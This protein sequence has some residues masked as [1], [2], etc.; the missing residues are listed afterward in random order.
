MKKLILFFLLIDSFVFGQ[1]N[2]YSIAVY[3]DKLKETGKLKLIVK[4]RGDESFK[5]PKK[6]NFCTM[7][8]VDLEF[9][10]NE[11]Q[12]FEKIKRTAKDIDCFASPDKFKKIKPYK[13]YKYEVDIKSDFN[14]IQSE[15]F[16]EVLNQ[17]KY[18]FKIHFASENG[19]ILITDWIYKN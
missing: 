17:S 16:F 18:R 2:N 7:R 10:N 4:N 5:V 19:E 1:K 6:L 9:F 11:I 15:N 8:I 14:I 12:S 3:A 13:I